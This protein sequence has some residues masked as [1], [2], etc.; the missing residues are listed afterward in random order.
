M[1]T[2]GEG[3][4]LAPAIEIV[5]ELRR[6]WG[7]LLAW[8]VALI[9][10]GLFAIGFSFSATL[11]TVVAFGTLAMVGGVAE[12]VGSFWAKQWGGLVLKLLAGVLYIVVGMLM[13]AHPI[14]AAAG[15]TLMIA[16]AL[17]VSGLLRVI[18]AVLHRFSGWPWVVLNGVIT[19]VLGVMIWR[20]W[21]ESALWVIGLFLGIDLVFSGWTWVMLALAVRSIPATGE[22]VRR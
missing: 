3:R 21:P 20:Q 8:G 4:L 22:V 14:G 6:N 1:N 11:G 17:M 7:W 9:V 15:L 16:A 18:V 10:I 5:G 12:I 2:V 19:L 13:L